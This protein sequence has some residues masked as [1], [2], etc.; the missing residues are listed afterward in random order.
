VGTMP[1]PPY[2]SARRPVD[3][4]DAED[5]QTIYARDAGA[6]AAPTAG[7]H[8]TDELFAR[9]DA[10]G[11]GRHF[12]TLHVG[13]GTFLPVKAADTKDHVMHAEWGTVAPETAAA[14]AV[15]MIGRPPGTTPA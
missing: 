11:I 12:V 1:L 5:Y 2:I 9:L 15:V 10:R 6:V 3:A 14:A 4:E 7:L 8:F 13:A